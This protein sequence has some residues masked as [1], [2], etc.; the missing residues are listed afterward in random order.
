M[1]ILM[2]LLKTIIAISLISIFFTASFSIALAQDGTSSPEVIAEEVEVKDDEKRT[3]IVVV[4][5]IIDEQAKIRDIFTYTISINNYTD[6]K[7]DLYAVV[8]DISISDGKQ[9]F[10]TPSRL[11]RQTSLA[12]WIK[13]S[14]GVIELGQGESKEVSLEINVSPDALPGKRYA[15]I[16]FPAAPNRYAAEKAVGGVGSAQLLIN[17]DVKEVIVEKAQISEFKASR[18]AYVQ[19]PVI[20][21]IAVQNFGNRDIAPQ[22]KI[23]LYNRRGEEIK[24][25]P[26]DFSSQPIPPEATGELALE[27]NI[28]KQLG[29]IKAKVELE[30]GGGRD[31]MDTIYIWLIP[32]PYLIGFVFSAVIVI[33]LLVIFLFRKTYQPG[34]KPRMELQE[35]AH[36]VINLKSQE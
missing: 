7:V 14:R 27:W 18:N 30:Y 10:I 3:G 2:K 34:H 25:L 19:P 31:L 20:F 12:R 11:D 24:A 4:P 13:I 6:R 32:L 35:D 16:S 22:G 9:E 28:D 8:N 29:K 1:T 15:M 33:I 21:N 36:G 23:Y 17:L 5:T 26:I